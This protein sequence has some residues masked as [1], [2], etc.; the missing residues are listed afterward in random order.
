MH[1]VAKRLWFGLALC[2]ALVA[3]L[4]PTLFAAATGQIKGKLI[5]KESKEPVIGASV[6]VKGT[7]FGATTNPDGEFVIP[8]LDPGTYVLVIS[9]VEYNTQEVKD[10]TV[11]ADLTAEVNQSLTKKVTELDTKITVTAQADIIDKFE[12]SNQTSISKESIKLR[13]VTS[14]DNLLRSVSGVQTTNTGQVFIRGGRDNEV[15]YI[16]DGVPI[17]DPLGGSGSSGA[18]LSLVSGSIQEI[19]IIKDGFDPEYGNALSGI[20]KIS[21]QTG[22]KDNTKT[23]I[24]YLTDDLG[25]HKLNKYSSNFDFLRFSL[26]GPDPI[27]KSRILPALGLNFL[28][29][30]EFTYYLYAEVEK[31]DG[32]YQFDK[33]DSP[34]TRRNWGTYDLLGIQIPERL[35]NRYYYMG[36]LKFRPKQNLNFIFSY[37]SSTTSGTLFGRDQWVYRYTS[38]TAPVRVNKWHTVS[39]EVSQELAKNTSYEAVF[40]YSD[41]STQIAPGDPN[42]PGNGLNPDQFLL[43]NQWEGY[44]DRNNNGIY[45]A[46]EPILN[47]FPDSANYGT[48]FNGAGYNYGEFFNEQN[49]QSGT[50]SPTQF[51]FNT[52]GYRDSLE[53]EPFID[54]NGNGVWD[55]GDYLNDVNH[56]GVLD[57]NRVDPINIHTPESYVD[58]DSIVGEPFTDVN[59]NGRFDS[60]IDGFVRSFDNTINQ[61]LNHNGRHDGPENLTPYQWQPPIPYVDRNGNGVY[62][63]P[64]NQYDVGEPFVDAN[65]NGGYDGGGSGAFLT[66]G[67]YDSESRW[68]YRKTKT[69][70]GEVKVF[71][72]MGPHELKGGVAI[73]HDDFESTDILYPYLEYLGRAD[74]G[75]YPNRGAFRDVFAYKPWTGTVY[76][77]DKLEYGSMVASLGIRWDFFLQ[78][79]SRLVQ[80]VKSDDLGSGTILGDRQRLS[81]RIGFSYPI[82]DKAKVHFNYGH[83]YQLPAYTYMFQRNTVNVDQNAVVGNYNLDYEKTVQYS[84]GVKYAMTENYSIDLSGYFKDEFDKINQQSVTLFNRRVNQY[85]NSDYGRSRGFELELEKQ[86]GGYVRGQV[87]YTY[88]FAYGKASATNENY[89]TDFALSRSPLDEAPLDNDYR[90]TLKVDLQVNIPGS[91]KP[92]L[93]GLRIPNDWSVALSSRIRSGQPFTPDAKYPNIS[94]T[95]NESIARNSLRYPSTAVFDVRFSKAFKLVGMDYSFILWVNNI[96]DARNVVSVYSLTGRADTQQNI[97][98]IVRQ[99][100]QLDQNPYNWDYG[101]QVRVG[102]EVNL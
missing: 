41:N 54:L 95:S 83:F 29:D 46:P 90:H 71:H 23:N 16:V 81:P 72:Q 35:F 102:L 51:R 4:S 91:V 75:K 9:S 36:N 63:P 101:R 92:R 30:K 97:D 7:K 24:Q 48:D 73:G 68:L 98:R 28:K 50:V 31:Q 49:V 70:R 18:N 20:V 56:N 66:P 80:V 55:R 89:L 6:L 27:L 59:G 21:T 14:V 2:V 87:S 45:D 10:V 62:D 1:G 19:Q 99:G 78:D 34:S 58:G 74:G 3:L 44:N 93:F 60:D 53:G 38:A 11:K 42:H 17:G 57:G 79:V 8:R 32:D 26:S 12:V 25:T 5:D 22:N 100:T 33:Y 76:F 82:S 39:L 69:L 77:R 96:F 86:G 43:D 64:N 88:A 85:R 15:G 84:F 37:K 47:M 61:D 65:G 52:N 94:A 67:S 40:S 13:P